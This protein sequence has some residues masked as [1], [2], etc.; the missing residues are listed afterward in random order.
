MP[1]SGKSVGEADWNALAR[2][3]AGESSPAEAEAIRE[4]LSED[5]ERQEILDS[6]V[7]SLAALAYRPPADLDV[8]SALCRA[9]AILEAEAGGELA[10]V[11]AAVGA[12]G[13]AVADPDASAAVVALPVGA[14]SGRGRAGAARFRPRWGLGGW[15]A[16]ALRAAAVF[17]VVAAGVVLWHSI[18]WTE[19]RQEALAGAQTFR[20]SVG[21]RD[22]VWLPDGSRVLLGPM[23]HLTLGPGYGDSRRELEMVGTAYFDVEPDS[24][25]PFVVRV[26]GGVVQVVG[27]SFAVWGGGGAEVKVV[28]E[29]GVVRLRS[30]AEP[31]EGGVLLEAGDRGL[32]DA[33]GRTSAER[34]AATEE[35]YA[36]RHGRLVFRDAPLDR[37]S[38]ELMRWYGVEVRFEDPALEARRLT[39]DFV[40]DPVRQVMEVIALALGAEVEWRGDT[41]VVRPRAEVA[42]A[43]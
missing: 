22:S 2:Y 29:E 23:S 28:V 38:A 27:T 30:A 10:G 40:G 37:V 16:L 1:D 35:D 4:W 19:R 5:P 9:K 31:E 42:P 18:E 3:V 33:D 39:A 14:G 43:R 36:W 15:G 26:G 17:A 7:R 11:G 13:A 6:L 12:E 21:Q 20:T 32:L 41:A 25:R 8:E 24:D 34:G